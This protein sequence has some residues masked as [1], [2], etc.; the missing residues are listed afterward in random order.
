MRVRQRL[1]QHSLEHAEY[2]RVRADTHAERDQSN[3]GEQRRA[4]QA[5]QNLSQLIAEHS[6]LLSLVTSAHRSQLGQRRSHPEVP[7]A[8]AVHYLVR[9][10][11]AKC[12][13]SR[14]IASCPPSALLCLR[15]KTLL[16]GRNSAFVR[17]TNIPDG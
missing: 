1:Q 6:P 15:N 4:P 16:P 10:L 17:A 2:H 9:C 14:T 12:F 13:L 8:C 7:R 3:N 11:A 5:S